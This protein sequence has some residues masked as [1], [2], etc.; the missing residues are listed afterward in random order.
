MRLG[1]QRV[2]L[3]F[4]WNGKETSCIYQLQ[5]MGPGYPVELIQS[6]PKPFGKMKE[7]SAHFGMGLYSS[8]ILCLKHGGTL[9][10]E[11]SKS[12]GATATASFQINQKP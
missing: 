4:I 8:Q 3:K 10:L 1:L 6:G 12:Y 9:T 7:D 11:N 2:K 5:T